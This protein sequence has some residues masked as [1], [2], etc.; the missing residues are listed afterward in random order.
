MLGLVGIGFSVV[1]F[2][3]ISSLLFNVFSSNQPIVPFGGDL[4]WKIYVIYATAIQTLPYLPN[5]SYA[6]NIGII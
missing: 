5:L 2:R 6:R 4:S 1:G 3:A